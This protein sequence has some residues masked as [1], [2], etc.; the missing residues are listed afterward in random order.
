MAAG[1]DQFAKRLGVGI[2]VDENLKARLAPAIESAFKATNISVAERSE[3]IRGI[4]DKSFAADF[5]PTVEIAVIVLPAS[6]SMNCTWMFSLVKQ[7]LMRGRSL[8]PVIFFRIRQRRS[9]CN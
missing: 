9:C 2:D 1:L 3:T 8:L 5:A 6:S 4:G 7:T